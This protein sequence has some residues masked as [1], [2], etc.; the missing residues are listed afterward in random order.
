MKDESKEKPEK[1]EG[2]QPQ[3]TNFNPTE[4]PHILTQALDAIARR[5]GHNW[6]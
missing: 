1:K 6:R 5:V 4:N 3:I 2:E